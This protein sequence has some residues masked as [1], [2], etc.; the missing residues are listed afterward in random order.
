MGNCCRSSAMITIDPE[1]LSTLK[2]NNPEFELPESERDMIIQVEDGVP[3]RQIDYEYFLLALKRYGFARK[4]D[5]RVM[6]F[7]T[8]ELRMNFPYD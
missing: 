1:T 6:P 5:Q 8:N 3:F 2:R 4:I 7:I